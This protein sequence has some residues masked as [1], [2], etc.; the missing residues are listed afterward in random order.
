MPQFIGALIGRYYFARRF[1]ENWPQYRVVFF[2][3]YGISAP[4]LGHDDYA[5]LDVKGKVVHGLPVTGHEM[6]FALGYL[7]LY[8]NGALV[9]RV[10]RPP[11]AAVPPGGSRATTA[12][13]T[14]ARRR[15]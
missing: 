4:E 11:A 10:R 15:R 14:A 1:K 3:G 9:L 2:A 6:A 7:V 13:P 5:G 8:E 12:R